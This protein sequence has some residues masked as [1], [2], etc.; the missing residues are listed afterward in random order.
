MV[1]YLLEQEL[2]RHLPRGAARHPA[3]PGDRRPGRRGVLAPDQ[4]RR[5]RLRRPRRPLPR[6]RARLGGGPR[7]RAVA[8]GRAVARAAAHRRDRHHPAAR[9]PRH[10]RHLRRRRRHPG[11]ARRPRRAAGRRGRH[12]QGPARPP[13][14]P[15]RSA[16]TRLL[17]L[18]DV[19][20]VYAGWGTAEP[21]PDPRDA[22]R[23]AAAR[24]RCRRGRWARRSTPSCR[25]VEAGGP[26]AAI[27][28]L[29]DAADILRGQAGTIVR[30]PDDR[31]PP[32][33]RWV[34]GAGDHRRRLGRRPDPDHHRGPVTR[35]EHDRGPVGRPDH[36]RVSDRN[37]RRSRADGAARARDPGGR[38]RGVPRRARRRLRGPHGT[39]HHRDH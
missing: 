33:P 18:T 27:G 35:S 36:H 2:G 9:R 14:S 22:A 3:H 17:L 31:A 11:R 21:R 15:P 37:D 6:P 39:P 26:M 10:H 4:V 7:R 38:R 8:A 29:A 24:S 34:A 23:P 5:T 28:A 13:S 12:R 16:P 19:D 20:A 1:G 32:R 25:F 30:G